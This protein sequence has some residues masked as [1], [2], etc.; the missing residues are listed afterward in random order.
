M[1]LSWIFFIILYIL[2]SGWREEEEIVRV[3]ATDNAAQYDSTA[4]YLYY[5]E[6]NS[7]L[8]TTDEVESFFLCVCVFERKG[9]IYTLYIR[10]LLMTRMWCGSFLTFFFYN[11]HTLAIPHARPT[12]SRAAK[13][14][15]HNASFSFREKN[16]PLIVKKKVSVIW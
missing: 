8:A 1:M 7:F 12:F 11:L 2:K 14:K 13:D 10:S 9:E 5:R 3:M 4:L 15:D 6:I 16:R